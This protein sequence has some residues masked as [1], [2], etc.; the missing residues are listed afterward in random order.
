MAPREILYF[1][2][3]LLRKVYPQSR[4]GHQMSDHREGE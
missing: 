4:K 2:T 1:V 3:S